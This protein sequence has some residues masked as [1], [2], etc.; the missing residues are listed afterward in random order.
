MDKFTVVY[1]GI[2]KAL[3]GVDT[4]P[5]NSPRV[6][7]A[8][9]RFDSRIVVRLTLQEDFLST[10]Y[11]FSS[12]VHYKRSTT[13]H[14]LDALPTATGGRQQPSQ[15]ALRKTRIL[16]LKISACPIAIT[17]IL[18]STNAQRALP[19]TNCLHA[20][21]CPPC[22]QVLFGFSDSLLAAHMSPK[23]TAVAR[24]SNQFK[25]KRQSV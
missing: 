22:I 13:K 3:L 2:P 12:R 25:V 17:K 11:H 20:R 7:N 15:I 1:Q 23:S 18:P 10:V 16:Q 8:H 5:I 24:A 9:A 14:C 4:I 6:N 19:W 21:N